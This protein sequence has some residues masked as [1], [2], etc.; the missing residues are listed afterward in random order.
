MEFTKSEAKQWARTHF[1]GLENVV[2]PSFT[3]DLSELD[4]EGIRHDVRYNIEQGFFSV[5]CAIESCGMTFEEQKHFLEI[6]ADE[7][8]GKILVSV[9]L[10]CDTIEQSIEMLHHAERVGCAHALLGYAAT[11]HPE[12]EEAIY[13]VT[14]KI[15]D[16][17][18]L[19]TVIYPSHTFDFGKFHPSKFNPSLLSRMADIENVVA[20]KIGII[21]SPGFTAECFRLMGDKIL[22]NH[23][24]DS[25]WPITIPQYGQQ[26][27][28]AT[29]YDVYQSPD[30]PRLIECFNLFVNG[31]FDRAMALHWELTPAR[32]LLREQTTS[33]IAGGGLRHTNL[34]KY[35]QWLVGGNGGIVRPPAA[36]LYE[37]EKASARAALR[38]IGITPREPDDEFYVGR[39]NYARGM[40]LKPEA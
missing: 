25:N 17:T 16:S 38:S 34:F 3:P 21:D 20:M 27:A 19:A 29:N 4:E 36:K 12:S 14:R 39:V 31:E 33:K 11:F 32:N 9:P 30:N 1:K 35:D 13:R 5:L 23:P 26:W 18:N 15:C 2:L 7:A 22:V 28:G 24:D 40:R 10:L 8:R 37:H 6:A